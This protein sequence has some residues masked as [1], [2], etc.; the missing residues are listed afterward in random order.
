MKVET[1]SLAGDRFYNWVETMYLH[2]LT[3]DLKNF[4]NRD[5]AEF[6]ETEG[7]LKYPLA[8][9]IDHFQEMGVTTQDVV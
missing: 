5:E 4:D 2:P 6:L 1:Q 3:E 9:Q 7:Q 8:V